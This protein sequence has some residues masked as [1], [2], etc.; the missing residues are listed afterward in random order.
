MQPQEENPHSPETS[1]S[2]RQKKNNRSRTSRVGSPS[3][4]EILKE[5]Q[6]AM[7]A[8]AS[9]GSPDPGSYRLTQEEPEQ[10]GSELESELSHS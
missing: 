6:K 5:R 3:P 7:E 9:L 8:A 10:S 2:E 4:M 1:Q